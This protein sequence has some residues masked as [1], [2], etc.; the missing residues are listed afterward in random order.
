MDLGL[1]TPI[2]SRF[3][4][5]RLRMPNVPEPATRSRAAEDVVAAPVIQRSVKYLGTHDLDLV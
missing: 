4:R 5:G 2:V 3:P 1:A